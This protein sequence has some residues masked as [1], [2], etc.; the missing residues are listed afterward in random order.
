MNLGELLTELQQNMLHDRSSQV[1]GSGSDQLWDP[2]T[3]VRYI[4]QAQDRFARESECIRDFQTPAVCAITTV[5]GQNFYPLHPS[6]IG[7]MSCR[8]IGAG[9]N[10]DLA[11]TGHSNL[12]TYQVPDTYFFN[13]QELS[14]L[15]PGKPLA[16]ATDEGVSANE[17]G[18]MEVMNLRL[19]PNVGAGYGGSTIQ[20]RVV[21]R[22][23]NKLTLRNLRGVPEIPSSYHLDMLDWAG[24]LAIRYADLDIAGT[25]QLIRMRDFK[26]SFNDTIERVKT[27]LKRKVFAPAIWGFG[28]NGF[29]YTNDW[30]P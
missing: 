28:R 10:A 7:V 8:N 20:L 27:Q 12:D 11:R 21:R 19:Y 29:S 15:Q 5:V 6:V 23:I 9:D 13:P 25:D 30:N 4:N 26:S 22:P 1:S 16:W 14:A 3:L 17:E 18:S 24:Y 2:E